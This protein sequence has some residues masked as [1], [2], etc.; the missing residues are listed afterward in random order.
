MGI[1]P[2]SSRG[3]RLVG[4]EF[5]L[6][7]HAGNVVTQES[8]AGRYRLVFF[9]FT[10]CKVVC[11]RNLARLSRVLEALGSKAEEV[12]PL[13][14]S[15]DPER[16]TPEVMRVFLGTNYPYFTG[17]TGSRKEVD[18]AKRAFR[19]FAARKADPEE[20]DGY[21]VPHTAI[22]YLMDR[23]GDYIAHFPEN[24]PEDEM[25]RRISAQLD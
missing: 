17:L 5:L 23:N 13:Y 12:V 8:Y 24:L 10:H 2:E 21:A 4:G 18:D 16:D 6:V 19:V 9:G 14:V 1:T 25:V 7:D 15:V 20:P 3:S 11:P 22:T